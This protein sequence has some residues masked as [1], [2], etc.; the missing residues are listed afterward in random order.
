MVCEHDFG[1]GR[2]LAE[3]EVTWPITNKPHLNSVGGRVSSIWFS[4][5]FLDRHNISNFWDMCPKEAQKAE[6]V[7]RDVIAMQH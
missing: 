1:E 7:W 6:C 3:H 4:S 2:C 5:G